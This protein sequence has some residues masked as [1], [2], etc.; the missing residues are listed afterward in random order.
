LPPQGQADSPGRTPGRRGVCGRRC[1][2]CLRSAAGSPGSPSCGSAG[3]DPHFVCPSE[4]QCARDVCALRPHELQRVNK[5]GSAFK[6]VHDSL[7]SK[8]RALCFLSRSVAPETRSGCW[9]W[10]LPTPGCRARARSCGEGQRDSPGLLSPPGEVQGK[11]MRRRGW[12]VVFPAPK[13][14]PVGGIQPA[15]CPGTV[16]QG[17]RG[18]DVCQIRASSAGSSPS[19]QGGEGSVVLRAR[20]VFPWVRVSRVALAAGSGRSLPSPLSPRPRRWIPALAAQVLGLCQGLAGA[21]EHCCS[22]SCR[23]GRSWGADLSCGSPGDNAGLCIMQSPGTPRGK[24]AV[25]G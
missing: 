9:S 19:F 11:E 13:S 16:G 25:P 14:C 8:E 20:V 17:V 6:G 18:R 10:W 7:T 12:A 15:A 24:I 4:Q 22:P 1:P 21:A 2:F 5:Q 3:R 23:A